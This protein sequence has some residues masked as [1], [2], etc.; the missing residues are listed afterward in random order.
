MFL[1]Y[2]YGNNILSL[3]KKFNTGPLNIHNNSISTNKNCTN[4][5]VY[6]Q[7]GTTTNNQLR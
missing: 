1:Y 3:R 7:I 6:R 2:D 5:F 4:L